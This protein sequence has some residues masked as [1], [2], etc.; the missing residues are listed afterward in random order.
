MVVFSVESFLSFPNIHRI[1]KSPMNV[2]YLVRS[3]FHRW[4]LPTLAALLL[5]VFTESTPLA[6]QIPQVSFH[7]QD[8]AVQRGTIVRIAIRAVFRQ[9]PASL[10]SIRFTVRYAPSS[11]AFQAAR[12]GG[13]NVMQCLT[14]RIDS[15]FVNLNL[16]AIRVSCAA[17]RSLPANTDTVTLATMDFRTLASPD[18]TTFLAVDSL[19]LNGRLL[20]PVSSRPAQIILQGAPLVAAEFPD[21][22]GQNFPNPANAEGTTFPYT[23]AASGLV[24]FALISSRGDVVTEFAPFPRNQGRHLFQLSRTSTLSGGMY[25]LRMITPR[26]V[27]Y[28]S[29]LLLK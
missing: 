15:Q 21:A 6:A 26:G 23:V 12:G 24:E 29:F 3:R 7:L 27:Y 10:D 8:T 18:I 17:L 13:S 22:I 5:L 25:V 4:I 1:H 20:F 14:P 9:L 19:S 11:L 28:R 2:F 16:G